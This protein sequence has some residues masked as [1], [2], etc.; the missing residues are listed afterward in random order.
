M[1]EWYILIALRS[2]RV[3]HDDI[4]GCIVGCASPRQQC[5]VGHRRVMRHPR[6]AIWCDCYIS[7]SLVRRT[8]SQFL[9]SG[10]LIKT[11]NQTSMK[12]FLK[13]SKHSFKSRFEFLDAYIIFL[14][15][16]QRQKVKKY[17]KIAV[18]ESKLTGAMKIFRLLS[19]K[20][21]EVILLS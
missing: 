17:I 2:I 9:H 16:A 13:S 7:T 11:I 4:V 20:M 12:S 6:K 10:R 21:F 3:D 5:L 8:L 1:V 14:F 18:N 19:H 15:K